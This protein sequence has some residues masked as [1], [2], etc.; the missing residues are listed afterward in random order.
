MIRIVS[1]LILFLLFNST[2][3]GQ[4]ILKIEIKNLVNNSGQLVMDFRDGEDQEI[5]AVYEKITNNQSVTTVN[6]LEPEK[7]SFKYFH[8]KNN[9]EKL[10]TYWI[11]APNEGYGFSNNAK[12]KFGPPK[13]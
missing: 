7:Y 11:G 9:N 13:F 1:L 10:D 12:A 8:D 5:K 2:I 6:D 3:R 4:V